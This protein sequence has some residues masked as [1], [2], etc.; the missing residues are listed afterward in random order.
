VLF[1]Y[2]DREH[3]EFVWAVS[4][5]GNVAEFEAAAERYNASAERAQAFEGQPPRVAAMH[6]AYV[7][8]VT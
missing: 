2:A 7:D 1:G 3:N 8:A 4:H 6:L 5:P